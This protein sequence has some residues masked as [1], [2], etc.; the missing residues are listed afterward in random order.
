MN[1]V[2][3]NRICRLAVDHFQ[4]YVDDAVEFFKH[5]D[6]EVPGEFPGNIDN[7]VAIG[8]KIIIAPTDDELRMFEPGKNGNWRTKE[9]LTFALMYLQERLEYLSNEYY[10][11]GENEALVDTHL[12]LDGITFKD[13]TSDEISEL[14][15]HEIDAAAKFFA[16]VVVRQRGWDV[17]D[18]VEDEDDGSTRYELIDTVFYDGSCDRDY[19]QR[20]LIGHDGYNSSIVCT[21][22]R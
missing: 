11:E 16:P 4:R 10:Y 7:E 8:S 18:L 15:D 12:T 17:Y 5:E 22:D 19:V 3:R 20:S 13:P 14:I 6:F 9:L 2:R 1:A 21:S